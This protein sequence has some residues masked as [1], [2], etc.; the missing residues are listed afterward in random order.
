[1]STHLCCLK[2]L[3]SVYHSDLC[4]PLYV[5]SLRTWHSRHHHDLLTV[6]L[7]RRKPSP[8]KC[9]CFTTLTGRATSQA[10]LKTSYSLWTSCCP[11]RQP[12][13]QDSPPIVVQCRWVGQPMLALQSLFKVSSEQPLE[14]QCSVN[15]RCS[16]LSPFY[17]C[18]AI[19]FPYVLFLLLCY[20]TLTGRAQSVG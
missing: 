1:M 14:L 9:S 4:Q 7:N 12:P 3:C 19:M 13:G 11:L 8:E 15:Y 10:A 6:L 5:L 20:V 16:E 18:S 17:V 2:P